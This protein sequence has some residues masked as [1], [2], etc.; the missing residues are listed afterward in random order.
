VDHRLVAAHGH[1]RSSSMAIGRPTHRRPPGES[2]SNANSGIVPGIAKFGL[3]RWSLQGRLIDGTGRPHT[4]M[5]TQS[6]I[7]IMQ[8][9]RPPA[10]SSPTMR[11]SA[12]ALQLTH[13]RT[14]KDNRQRLGSTTVHSGRSPPL[15]IHGL[16]AAAERLPQSP[17]AS[18]RLTARWPI[19][20][21]RLTA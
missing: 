2:S 18:S 16:H 8:T 13:A 14:W 21:S 15:P 4:Y 3:R 6:F 10:P 1:T 7:V 5:V 12:V 20:L 11:T 9:A 17:S 19:A